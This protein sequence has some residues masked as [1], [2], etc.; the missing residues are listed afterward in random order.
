VTSTAYTKTFSGRN[1]EEIR[2]AI[3][4]LTLTAPADS[5]R[6]FFMLVTLYDTRGVILASHRHLVK[7]LAVADAPRIVSVGDLTL[8]RG[9]F[10]PIYVLVEASEDKSQVLLVRLTVPRDMVAGLIGT[11]DYIHMS[12]GVMMMPDY[13]RGVFA[14]T[15][16]GNLKL[17]RAEL[18]NSVL[19]G[20][21]IVFRPRPE[22]TG[23]T[24]LKVEA[25][26]VEEGNEVATYKDTGAKH[27]RM[28]IATSFLNV[29]VIP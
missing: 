26:S 1:N 25:I 12:P 27:P 13:R 21:G 23:R 17:T 3:D 15:A 14:I 18:L 11:I 22:Y 16:A 19:T 29:T 9:S 5:D 28:A 4:S 24:Q 8:N 2:Q 6:D 7:V 20:G 10:E